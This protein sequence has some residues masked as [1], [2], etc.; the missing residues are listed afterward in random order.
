MEVKFYGIPAGGR[1]RIYAFFYAANGWQ[2][3]QGETEWME[4]VGTGDTT[5]LKKAL[6]ITTNEIPLSEKSV[7]IHKQKIVYEREGH[8]WK[9]T[10]QAPTATRKTNS[11]YPGK[12]IIRHVGITVAQSPAMLGYTWQGTGLNVPKD[13]PNAPKTNEALYT[14]QN[15]SLLQLPEKQ[16][17]VPKV[18]FS[19]MT[20]LLYDIASKDDGTGR[21]FFIDTTDGEFDGEKRPEGGCHIRRVALKFDGNPPDFSTATGKSWGRFEFPMDKYVFHPAGYVLGISYNRHKVFVVNLSGETTDK[22]APVATMISGQGLRDGLIDGPEAIAVALDGRLL[23]LEGGNN[24]I[25]SFDLQGNPVPYFANPQKPGG[26]KIPTMSLATTARD[27]HY[28]DLAVEAKGYIYVLAYKGDGLSPAD[29][30]VD[31]YKP[32][33]AFL[34]TTTGVAAAKMIVDTLRSLYT[35]NYEVILGRDGRPEPSIS[36]WLPPPPP[37]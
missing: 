30:R 15:L 6:V 24:R 16:Y 12:D 32:D 3:G 17:A 14:F 13:F 25:Q 33:G 27:S 23:V 7:Y 18:G 35:L 2:S 28:L 37:K 5:T 22:A 34:V 1:L 4:A 8:R 10:D 31:I 26:D 21:N 11:P 9:V 29:Y 19:S 36:M 20:S